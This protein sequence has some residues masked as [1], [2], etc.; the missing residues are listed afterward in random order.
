MRTR[1]VTF[2]LLDY[3][4]GAKQIY[5]GN[6]TATLV[7]RVRAYEAAGWTVYKVRARSLREAA[8]LLAK[9]LYP[10]EGAR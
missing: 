5:A 8:D 4:G 6:N 9:K 7:K 3:V 1:P 2:A 10:D